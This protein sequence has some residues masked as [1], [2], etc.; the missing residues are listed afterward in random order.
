M[1]D[2]E[3]LSATGFVVQFYFQALPLTTNPVSSA[4]TLLN[5]A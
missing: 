2:Y 4:Y 3:F 1:M 5:L